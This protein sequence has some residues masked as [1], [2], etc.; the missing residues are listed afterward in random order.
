MA[1]KRTPETP[2]LRGC[3]Y[4]CPLCLGFGMLEHMRPEVAEHLSAAGR[5]L[6]LALRA[7]LESLEDEGGSAR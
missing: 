2:T 1:T 7:C 6:M 4:P 3:P 5:E